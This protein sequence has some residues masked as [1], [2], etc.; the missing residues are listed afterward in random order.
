MNLE[1]IYIQPI[2]IIQ[3][4]HIEG[5]ASNE[6][7]ADLDHSSGR[8]VDDEDSGSGFGPDDDNEDEEDDDAGSG[9][10]KLKYLDV[11]FFSFYNFICDYVLKY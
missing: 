8:G 2:L 10:C 3:G 11:V 4:D 7:F 9:G 1:I 5:S 6:E